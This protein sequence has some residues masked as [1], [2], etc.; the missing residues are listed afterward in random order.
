MPDT[1]VIKEAARDPKN[2][3]RLA[4]ALAEIV[5]FINDIYDLIYDLEVEIR[6]L[7]DK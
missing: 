4:Y 6:E 5:Q 3:E 7:K 2:P 1:E